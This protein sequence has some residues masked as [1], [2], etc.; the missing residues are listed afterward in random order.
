MPDH[1][2][3]KL[4]VLTMCAA[5]VSFTPSAAAQDKPEKTKGATRLAT[6]VALFR[7]GGTWADLPEAAVSPTSLLLGGGGKPKPFFRL[8]D[9]LRDTAEAA[10]PGVVLFDLSQPASFGAA[11]LPELER[12]IEALRKAGKRT[13]AYLEIADTARYQIACAC[14]EI[15]MA[16]M[17]VLD[18][19][20]ASLSTMFFRDALDLLGV[21]FDVVR[22]GDFKG[23]VEPWTRSSMSPHL[24]KHYLE[25]LEGVNATLVRRVAR[26]RGLDESR[27][28]RLQSERLLLARRAKEAGLVDRLVPWRGARRALAAVL[29][30]RSFEM[31]DALRARRRPINFMALLGQLMRPAAKPRL[32]KGTIVVLHLSGSI[33][34][35][36]EDLPGQIASGPTVARIDDLAADDAVAGVVV[37]INSPGGSA[38]A[39]EAILLALRELAAKKPVVCSMGNLAAS[40]G[41]YVTCFSRPIL[42]EATTLTGSIGVFGLKPN[43]GP[44]MR[45]IGLHQELV[46]LD[47]AAGM[48]AI[49]RPW[50]DPQR[51]RMQALVNAVYDRFVGHVAASRK[52]SREEVLK[53]AGGRVWSGAQAVALGLVDRIGGLYDAIESVAEQAGLEGKPEVVH[54]PRPRSFL[55][56]LAKMLDGSRVT[57]GAAPALEIARRAGFSLPTALA[58]LRPDAAATARIF[59]L[60]EAV[61]RIR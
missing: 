38:T 19:R 3:S 5:F 52:K 16:D 44:L 9:A 57:H 8:T 18:F 61:V 23:A 4:A 24:R 51:A 53:I 56:T 41:Y 47:D 43:L 46:A 20:S 42:A 22:C 12:R 29:G 2:H 40:G 48:D 55:A 7:L 28:R 36:A 14:D 1:S 11:H 45:R 37:R 30:N 50:S 49:D 26:H 35:G 58:F 34:D 27:V 21:R 25:L 17:G 39:S 59:C 6:K 31:E 13:I 32:K 33:V 54:L 60:P 15:V 10:D